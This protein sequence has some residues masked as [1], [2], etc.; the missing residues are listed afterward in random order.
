M[1]LKL[2]KKIK[3]GSKV[4]DHNSK[5]YLIGEVSCNHN[6]EIANAKKLILTAKKFGADAVKFQTYTPDTITLKSDKKDF[7]IKSGL[8]KGKTL[9]DLYNQAQTPFEWFPKLFKFAKE[10]KIDCF[11]SPFDET[12]VDL[13]EKLKCPFY[14]LASFELNHIP[15]IK[16]IAKTKKPIIMSTGMA[17]LK[18]IDLA[19][20][21]ANNY[22]C[23]D[24]IILY[25]V[26]AYPAK[27]TD[28]NLNNL[29]IIS[30]RYNNCIVGLSDH[31]N[32]PDIII[33]AITCGAKVVEKHIALQNQK[34]GFDIKF[35]IKGKD[36][37][38]LKDSMIKA[39]HLLGKKYFYR[40]KDELK[41]RIFR[42]SI[43]TTKNIKKKEIINENLIKVVRPAFG[44]D[45]I[46]YDKIIGKK[47]K[48]NIKKDVGLKI[49]DI[50]FNEK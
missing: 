46:F 24:I 42:R 28:F 10:K 5:P 7:K 8:W 29:N 41:N 9:W 11:S 50:K 33:S 17:N 12:A 4:I 32:D 49:N 13:L 39:H 48:R 43:Y 1:N 45:P 36:I 38:K 23:K 44:L 30:T 2:N 35:S 6:G 40:N 19:V 16:K 47:A 21:T 26:S 37:K 18:E 27:T 20:K 14:K 15:L 31:S 22:G 34:K 3:L 25:T